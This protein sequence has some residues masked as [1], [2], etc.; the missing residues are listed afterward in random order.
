M[1]MYVRS[2]VKETTPTV[3]F[4]W[5][6]VWAFL[7]QGDPFSFS[8]LWDWIYKRSLTKAFYRTSQDT[9]QKQSQV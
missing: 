2:K 3:T 5:F 1:H 4:Y 9:T 6:K 7:K 8:V